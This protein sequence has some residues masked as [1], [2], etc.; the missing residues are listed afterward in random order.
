MTENHRIRDQGSL[1]QKTHTSFC[2]CSQLITFNT[3]NKNGSR[4][5]RFN[6]QNNRFNYTWFAFLRR[7][8]KPIKPSPANSMA[9]VSGS[10]TGVAIRFAPKVTLSKAT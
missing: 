9:Y 5:S 6:Y 8:V 7:A 1:L 10:G 3:T 2:T 4:S